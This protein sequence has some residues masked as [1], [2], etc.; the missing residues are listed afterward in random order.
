MQS[1]ALA[2]AR[3]KVIVIEAA[4]LLR[5]LTTGP[6]EAVWFEGVPADAVCIGLIGAGADGR[7]ELLVSSES[8]EPVEAADIP[9]LDVTAHLVTMVV[10][11]G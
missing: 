6:N 5:V 9:N 4:D 8:F 2:T 11:H 7:L 3:V 1:V 10:P